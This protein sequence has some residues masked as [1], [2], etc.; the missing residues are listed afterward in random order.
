MTIAAPLWDVPTAIENRTLWRPAQQEAKIECKN[1][2]Y[3]PH[4][5]LHHAF[6]AGS[7]KIK[8]TYSGPIFSFVDSFAGVLYRHI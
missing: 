2:A 1:S 8:A 7:K 6:E 3:Q 5:F 4:R